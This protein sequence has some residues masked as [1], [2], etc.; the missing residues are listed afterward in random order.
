MWQSLHYV[1]EVFHDIAYK[2]KDRQDLL[3]GI[4]EF[5]DEVI[6]LPPGEW[7]PD[8]RIEPPK[9]L[10]SADKRKHMYAGAEAPEMNGDA[11]H[12]GSGGGGGGHEV[13]E[14]LQC[15]R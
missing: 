9:S 5:L 13:G 6:V 7:D 12:D 1:K 3:A 4:E 15:T 11:H 10:P 8:I 2:A 14:E